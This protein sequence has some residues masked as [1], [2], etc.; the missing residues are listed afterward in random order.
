M[1]SMVA[2]LA[3]QIARI[4]NIKLD[5]NGPVKAY[6]FQSQVAED[7]GQIHVLGYCNFETHGAQ[8]HGGFG[9]IGLV[10]TSG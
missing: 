8:I 7:T 3:A 6:P 10:I 2:V 9:L 4:S 1:V 5:R